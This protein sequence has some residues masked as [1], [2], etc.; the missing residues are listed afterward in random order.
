VW[1]ENKIQKQVDAAR[2]F[3]SAGFI[4]CN[5]AVRYAHL[6]N[7]MVEHFSILK[8]PELMNY[9]TILRQNPLKVL[10][11]EHFVG[12]TSAAFIKR[13][14][15]D[16]VGLFDAR[17]RSSQ[18]YE[19]F[20]RLAVKT[21]FVVLSDVLFYKKNHPNNV[22]QN[23]LRTRT[24]HHD[25]LCSII[26]K[27]RKYIRRH[28]LE[29]ICRQALSES[30]FYLGNL[31]YEAKRPSEAYTSFFR[32]FWENPTPINFLHFLWCASKKTVRVITFDKV[33]RKK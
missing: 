19:Y 25:A 1:F 15:M 18:D 28:G 26:Q 33:R 11:Q 3:P 27:E 7:R 31:Q 9:D 13:E 22:S 14:V 12:T 10:I 24:Y 8:K 6:G 21:D 30:F 16:E 2:R 32:G 20:L 29:G 17:Y 23:V 4:S 5:F